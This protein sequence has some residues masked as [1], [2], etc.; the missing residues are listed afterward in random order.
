MPCRSPR[1]C[2]S[3]A[4][5]PRRAPRQRTAR[6]VDSCVLGPGSHRGDPRPGAL[7]RVE[8]ALL[9]PGVA[10]R[11]A[12]TRPACGRCRRCCSTARRTARRPA[13]GPARRTRRPAAAPTGRARGRR[14]RSI[15]ART[16]AAAIANSSAPM[17]TTR[18]RKRLPGA[19]AS[20]ASGP[21]RRTSAGPACA[22]TARR[23]AGAAASGPNSPYDVG[24]R[25]LAGHQRAAATSRRSRS[26]CAAARALARRS[27][28]AVGEVAGRR[29]VRVDRLA[30]DEQAHDLAS[31]PRRSG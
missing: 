21:S 16:H 2:S 22:T 3:A 13:A 30:G 5:A 7:A 9:E 6:Q 23:T 18:P 12:P 28:S 19:P 8:H 11:R 25:A 14:P 20:P 24:T 1:S 26:P 17:S 29:E 4:D 10:S 31:S 27:A 15:S